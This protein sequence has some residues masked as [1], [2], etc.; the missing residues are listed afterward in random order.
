EKLSKRG[1]DLTDF[2]KFG[3]LDEKRRKLIAQ[4]EVLKAERNNVS[5]QIAEMKRNKENADDVIA[6]MRE[7]GDEIKELDIELRDVE[8][9]L[10]YIMM[11][12]PNIPHE[13]VP[14]G[15]SEE[16]NVEV[17]TWGEQP[18]FNFEPKPH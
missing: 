17:R 10:D 4:T 16:D 5:G 12:I 11:R 1:E 7:V 2:D 8:E 15:D 14:F 9:K 6:R 13:S 3:D 18:A